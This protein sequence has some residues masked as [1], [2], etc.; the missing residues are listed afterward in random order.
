MWLDDNAQSS[1]IWDY[2][3]LPAADCCGPISRWTFKKRAI[4]LLPPPSLM[5]IATING[6]SEK[7]FKNM[8]K[9]IRV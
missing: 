6:K 5:H 2:Y 4:I 7:M 1:A 9:I 8:I 3:Y